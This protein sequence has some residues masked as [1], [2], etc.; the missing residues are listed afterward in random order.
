MTKYITPNDYLTYW[1]QNLDM[2]LP[3]DLPA[4]IFIEQ[5]ED[6]VAMLL[7]VNCFKRI[8]E[9]YIELSDYQKECYKKALLHQ[10]R[11]KIKNGDISNDSGYDP[12]S[13]K[14]ANEKYLEKIE[15]SRQAK[16]Y[17]N[18]AG[19]WNRNIGGKLFGGGFFP[20]IK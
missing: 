5:I 17:L 4:D 11:Y 9:E 6:E 7:E 18:L 10:C 3:Q 8:D 1:H 13:G 2:I 14:I 15:L 16:K 12:Q 19:L 20:V